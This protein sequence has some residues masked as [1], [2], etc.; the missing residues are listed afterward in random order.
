MVL[1]RPAAAK[2]VGRIP[3]APQ[4]APNGSLSPVISFFACRCQTGG[5][6]QIGEVRRQPALAHGPRGR[7][8]VLSD[9]PQLD[10]ELGLKVDH[11]IGPLPDGV[12]HT[13]A[14][15]RLHRALK[16]PPSRRGGAP[17][18]NAGNLQH[19]HTIL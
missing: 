19:W 10:V 14:S 16:R 7:Y 12:P 13:P 1:E 8:H 6:K 2:N 3:I 17:M 18:P 11:D 9:S 4:L 15:V 5:L